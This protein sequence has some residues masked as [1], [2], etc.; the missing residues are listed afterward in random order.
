M[1]HYWKLYDNNKQQNT[2]RVKWRQ[3]TTNK[4]KLWIGTRNSDSDAP[5]MLSHSLNYAMDNKKN[6]QNRSHDN[7]TIHFS[8]FLS[9]SL[10]L[11][12][13]F[14]TPLTWSLIDARYNAIAHAQAINISQCQMRF[15]RLPIDAV[16]K[17]TSFLLWSDGNA[18]VIQYA[19]LFRSTQSCRFVGF[20]KR[21][22][23]QFRRCCAPRINY[24]R[25]YTASGRD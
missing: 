20:A 15:A 17:C 8:L 25:L 16:V 24:S 22:A 2:L 12:W 14:N 5:Q 23:L 13:N 9:L 19:D 1:D 10:L 3:R 18:D 6:H 4:K 7:F 11:K 21:N